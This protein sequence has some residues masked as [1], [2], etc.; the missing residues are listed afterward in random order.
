MV[1]PNTFYDQKYYVADVL[2][3]LNSLEN[4]S[5]VRTS[6]NTAL[7][8]GTHSDIE[9]AWLNLVDSGLTPSEGAVL[10]IFDAVNNIIVDTKHNFTNPT[11]G[12]VFRKF[13]ST[14]HSVNE[15]CR[16]LLEYVVTVDEDTPY[17]EI[18]NAANYRDLIIVF[19]VRASSVN[20]GLLQWR[21]N[22]N[23]SSVYLTNSTGY[24]G[25]S[26]HTLAYGTT[27]GDAG[28]I[29]RD[30]SEKFISSSCVLWVSNHVD[31]NFIAALGHLNSM[32]DTYAV[33]DNRQVKMVGHGTTTL[34][35][36]ITHIQ[37]F[38]DDAALFVPG[39]TLQVFGIHPVA[40]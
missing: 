22:A 37:V 14:V 17:L 7:V 23:A 20:N 3:R 2:T 30:D 32:H 19:N 16:L 10:Q 29:A 18:P 36:P 4:S 39:S 11:T 6:H 34:L 40:T 8:D 25:N 1:W 9:N 5:L 26:R 21:Y 31:G 12:E 15:N 38:A 24:D 28:Y 33:N 27:L 13:Q 35:G